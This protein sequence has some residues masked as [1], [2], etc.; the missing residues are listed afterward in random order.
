[1]CTLY[2]FVADIVSAV[3]LRASVLFLC[4]FLSHVVLNRFSET[5]CSIFIECRQKCVLSFHH[6]SIIFCWNFE[7]VY[8]IFFVCVRVLYIQRFNTQKKIK[9]LNGLDLW[10]MLNLNMICNWWLD[11]IQCNTH[12]FPE[13]FSVWR[14]FFYSM[15]KWEVG[16][17]CVWQCDCKNMYVW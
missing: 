3:Q 4:F 17:W 14:F 1:M 2:A 16:S 15:I 8:Q 10:E 11:V 5:G 13:E 7:G 12:F 9:N 6:V